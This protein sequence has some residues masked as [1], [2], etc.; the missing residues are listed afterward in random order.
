MAQNQWT[1]RAADNGEGSSNAI[2][3]WLLLTEEQI[4]YFRMDEVVFDGLAMDNNGFINNRYDN[5][6]ADD[7]DDDEDNRN[8]T[9]SSMSL[10]QPE[11]IA[12]A[13][14]AL[15]HRAKKVRQP[16]PKEAN[17]EA[18]EQIILEEKM[19]RLD[20]ET[21]EQFNIHIQ[22]AEKKKWAQVR[23]TNPDRLELTSEDV[24]DIKRKFHEIRAVYDAKEVQGQQLSKNTKAAYSRYQVHWRVW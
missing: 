18:E 7:L 4:D 24:A 12:P 9:A 11:V 16:L 22:L 5:E 2:P 8:G 21:L 13:A 23:R 6:S 15:A 14:R 19:R 10:R 3:I 17:M 1:Y 20:G